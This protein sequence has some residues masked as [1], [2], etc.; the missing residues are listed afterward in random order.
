M[1]ALELSE[2]MA[3]QRVSQLERE[4]AKLTR[5]NQALMNRVERSMDFR[6]NAFSLFQTAIGLESKVRDRTRQLEQALAELEASHM[7][8]AI[9]K[10]A[11][12]VAQA[13]MAER[14][15]ALSEANQKLQ[16][17]IQERRLIAEALRDAKTVAEQA[18][19]SKTRF[20]AAASH[21]LLQPLN[22]ARLFVAS[23]AEINLEASVR[24]LVSGAESALRS[25][26]DLLEA[27]LEISKLDAGAVQADIRDFPL[28]DLLS[29]M[30][31]EFTPIAAERGLSLVI[32]NSGAI[33]KSD[34]RLLRR[35][36]QNLI[37]NAVK[38]TK[39][40]RIEVS[41]QVEDGRLRVR[42]S[43]TGPGIPKEKH[44]EI[45]EEF[46]RLENH[47]SDAAHRGMGLG[48]AIVQ[49]AARMLGHQLEVQSIVGQ[50]SEFSILAPIGERRPA[51]PG[52]VAATLANR[53]PLTGARILVIDNEQAILDGMQ[54]LLAAWGCQV[55]TALSEDA[56]I[57][58]VRRQAERPDVLVAD[59]HLSQGK[60][61]VQSVDKVRGVCG[62]AIP[63]LVITANRTAEVS[64]ILA[65]L[66]Y[67]V[68]AKPVKPA[69]LRA[70]LTQLLP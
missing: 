43:D 48:L 12:E 23:L 42:V 68:L 58:I 1:T 55:S 41:S 24:R 19:L 17:E 64:D 49:R 53:S 18:N 28:D 69:Q 40:G 3:D 51:Q 26:E 38:Y 39:S 65:N 36:L 44:T 25:V 2:S 59:Y 10:E 27:L 34:V 37:G 29:S 22:A 9:A 52:V 60:T 35:I 47:S 33:V 7:A 63:A 6:G 15:A 32:L 61:G 62:H 8:L 4:V 50:G 45:F 13:G 16:Q 70:V 56:A 30:R 57:D 14:T 66:G 21:D 54:A 31:A 5:I 20:L 46:R 11:A 67:P